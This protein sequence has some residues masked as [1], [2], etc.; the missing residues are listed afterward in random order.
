MA[1]IEEMKEDIFY[2]KDEVTSSTVLENVPQLK[3]DLEGLNFVTKR[4]IDYLETGD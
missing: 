2:W 3:K 4:L 1:S